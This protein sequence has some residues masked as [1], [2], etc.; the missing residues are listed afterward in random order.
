MT[1]RQ[2]KLIYP[3]VTFLDDTTGGGSIYVAL[4]PDL[5]GCMSQGDTPAEARANLDDAREMYI[6]S[7]VEDGLPVPEPHSWRPAMETVGATVTWAW[8]WGALK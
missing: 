6:A 1:T 5:P 4:H 8:V 3:T 2:R 7:L